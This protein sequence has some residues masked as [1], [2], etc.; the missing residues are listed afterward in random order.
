MYSILMAL[1]DDV[2]T[3]LQTAGIG[4]VGTDIFK[5]YAPDNANAGVYVLDTGGLQPNSDIK[6]LRNP[7]I[8]VFIRS[9]TYAAGKTKLEAVRTAI[10]Q[11]VNTTIGSTYVYFCLLQSEGGHIGRN[12][13][14]QDEF[15]MNFHLNTR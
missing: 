4:T 8:Q 7:T 9:A 1:I 2:A 12:E 5:S 14:G 3:Y 13:R 15:S 10:H 11:L 6:N